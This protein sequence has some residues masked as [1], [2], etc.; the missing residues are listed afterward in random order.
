M[1]KM[2]KLILYVI[3]YN[4]TGAGPQDLISE[5]REQRRGYLGESGIHAVEAGVVEIGEWHDDH[6]LNKRDADHEKYFGE[7]IW[8]KIDEFQF[9]PECAGSET[10]HL[11]PGLV[12]PD[13]CQYCG[14]KV[15]YC[16][17]N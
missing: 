9:E 3:D 4:E 13:F 16:D 17:P 15:L 8:D 6:P 12:L 14:K 7:C 5:L 2:T 10:Y 11:T 1:A